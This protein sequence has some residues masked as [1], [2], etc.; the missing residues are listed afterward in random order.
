MCVWSKNNVDIIGA[1]IFMSLFAGNNTQ[2]DVTPPVLLAAAGTQKRRKPNQGIGFMYFVPNVYTWFKGI[3]FKTI[4]WG[5]NWSRGDTLKPKY[6]HD[7]FCRA[8]STESPRFDL[9][10]TV[11]ILRPTSKIPIFAPENNL[12]LNF[13]MVSLT[14]TIYALKRSCSFAARFYSLFIDPLLLNTAGCGYKPV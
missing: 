6:Y 9:Y 8:F 10:I 13:A 1:W 7:L 5:K 12:K 2:A 4:K 3:L 11:P 14:G